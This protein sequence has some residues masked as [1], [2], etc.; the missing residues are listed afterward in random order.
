MQWSSSV[1]PA[2]KFQERA[3]VVKQWLDQAI[4]PSDSTALPPT[5][6]HQ[7][8]EDAIATQPALHIITQPAPPQSRGTRTPPS[9]PRYAPNP[10]LHTPAHDAPNPPPNI[11]TT[12]PIE[13]AFHPA[14]EEPPVTAVYPIAAR[15]Y[16]DV[17][18][19]TG[20][21]SDLVICEIQA[22]EALT[23][24][25][26]ID[27]TSNDSDDEGDDEHVKADWACPNDL[28]CDPLLWAGVKQANWALHVNGSFSSERQLKSHV[29]ITFLKEVLA[30]IDKE[31]AWLSADC[32]NG[33]SALLQH[34]FGGGECAL[35]STFAM[36]TLL[37]DK[38][39][40]P[41]IIWCLTRSSKYWEKNVWIIPIHDPERMHW[42]LE[43]LP[44]IESLVSLLT[45]NAN[46]QGY[47]MELKLSEWIA[48]PLV[49]S[50]AATN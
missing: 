8:P 23:L 10:F 39:L 43:W 20:S 1:A 35:I 25:D 19:D 46:D 33:C 27:E 21:E 37:N 24:A 28:Q 31:T 26:V 30:R 6:T 17:D 47:A 3:A 13:G 38:R 44:K 32:V 14:Q 36:Q 41:A 15:V 16:Y 7:Q 49:V 48:R 22:P 34:T 29:R 5:I 12:Q 11:P 45:T 40:G 50:V 18:S 2:A 9:Q 4:R 42:F